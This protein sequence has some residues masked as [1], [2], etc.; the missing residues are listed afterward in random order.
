MMLAFQ[1]V[2][3]HSCIYTNDEVFA[4]TPSNLIQHTNSQFFLTVSCM[5]KSC[6]M[7]GG[8]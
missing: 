1:P 4:A 2:C 6:S 8:V 5:P 3:V 7:L